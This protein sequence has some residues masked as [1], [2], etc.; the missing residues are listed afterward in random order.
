MKE[1]MEK[2]EQERAAMIEEVE[3][4]IERALVSMAVGM[5]D[6]ASEFSDDGSQYSRPASK[7]G[8]RRPS[9]SGR[10]SSRS[11]H[12]R[13]FATE[14]TLAESSSKDE[15]HSKVDTVIEENEDEE[16]ERPLSPQKKKRFSAGNIGEAG[17]DGIA[18]VD[19]GIHERTDRI[20]EKML[21]IQQKVRIFSTSA[22]KLV[23]DLLC[24]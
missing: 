23:S 18:A 20:A 9:V 3:A 13:S 22:K 2:M 5:D 7:A 1:T 8:S 10:S 4:Q 6:M 14:T 21:Q 11:R 19:E 17:Q 12:M 15:L 24:A 16:R